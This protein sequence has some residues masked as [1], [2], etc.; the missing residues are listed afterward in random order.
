MPV[1]NHDAKKG[2]KF[3]LAE[4]ISVLSLAQR[5]S[6]DNLWSGDSSGLRLLDSYASKIAKIC[7]LKML[8][9]AVG[10]THVLRS[11]L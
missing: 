3:E 2:L 4:S 8:R 1:G 5:R 9:S 7:D 6:A 11:D 10:K